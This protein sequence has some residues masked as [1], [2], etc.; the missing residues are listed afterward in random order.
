MNQPESSDVQTNN[1]ASL[2]TNNNIT[3]I[4]SPPSDQPSTLHYAHAARTAVLCETYEPQAAIINYF[5]L[6]TS[7]CAH[8][9]LSEPSLHRPLVSISLGCS[10]IFLM[11]DNNRNNKPF[12]FII[13]SGDMVVFTGP[14]R[15][16]Y[17]GVPRILSDC[18]EYLYNNNNNNN[19][20]NSNNSDVNNNSNSNSL[21]IDS[22]DNNEVSSD[23][24]NSATCSSSSSS[25]NNNSNN[26]N[27]NVY[28]GDSRM[29]E[30]RININ[31]R[32]VY[33]E[34][35]LGIRGI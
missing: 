25:D 24:T 20:N 15:V 4:N 6:Y 30:L 14:A 2:H 17:H 31:V 9:D 19:N 21:Y 32:Q 10:C 26:N 11:G 33:D 22:S 29:K 27:N 7:M 1:D 13:R 16:A 35:H 28:S 12:A 34:P 5:P 23:T 8:Q 18:P 3:N